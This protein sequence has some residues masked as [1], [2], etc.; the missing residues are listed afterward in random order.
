MLRTPENTVFL[1]HESVS[2]G[3]G[4]STQR[5]HA[6]W[7]DGDATRSDIVA[8]ASDYS[9]AEMQAGFAD[10]AK[11]LRNVLLMTN[12]SAA[13]A[14][15][16]KWW[17]GR[18]CSFPW[19]EVGDL[20]GLGEGQFA[21]VARVVKGSGALRADTIVTL[22]GSRETADRDKDGEPLPPR[23]LAR[24][25]GQTKVSQIDPAKLELIGANQGL[26]GCALAAAAEK[27]GLNPVWL[28]SRAEELGFF[29][30]AQPLLAEKLFGE[31]PFEGSVEVSDG[32][33]SH[34]GPFCE[35]GSLALQFGLRGWDALCRALVEDRIPQRLAGESYPAPGE[36][37]QAPEQSPPVASDE[38]APVPGVE[39]PQ[40][41]AQEPPPVDAATPV[42]LALAATEPAPPSAP[43]VEHSAA[44]A[45]GIAAAAPLA[46][47]EAARYLA[48]ALANGG[49][50]LCSLLDGI[51]G[52][53]DVAGL[54][55]EFEAERARAE[56]LQRE[57]DEAHAALASERARLQKVFS[58]LRGEGAGEGEG[59]ERA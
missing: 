41:P 34:V 15:W 1:Y 58:V 26:M 30:R 33:N 2:R 50:E 3:D 10:A 31:R 28:I 57:L 25:K 12:R 21:P 13:I 9:S 42:P 55:A 20:M 11:I 39:R 24:A 56:R 52:P 23:A 17:S 38:P 48:R 45:T 47:L 36:P 46:V 43:A 16:V 59:Y 4:A 27:S 44:L 5:L 14:A 49:A 18:V 53:G 32:A 22:V 51:P 35:T 7:M 37:A 8:V 6:V 40:A 54:R 29:S 19:A